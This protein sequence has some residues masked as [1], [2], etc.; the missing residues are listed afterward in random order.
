MA[1]CYFIIIFVSSSSIDT[2]G[3][4]SHCHSMGTN[5]VTIV[6]QHS[7]AIAIVSLPWTIYAR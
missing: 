2:N 5:S 4:C 3:Y 6:S 1:S 7:L